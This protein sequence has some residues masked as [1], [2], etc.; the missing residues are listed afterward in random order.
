MA[1]DPAVD[2]P[3]PQRHTRLAD[4]PGQPLPLPAVLQVVAAEAQQLGN[5]VR[6]A[7]APLQPHQAEVDRAASQIH[8]QH[9]APRGQA[10]SDRRSGGLIHQGEFRHLQLAAGLHQP[11]AVTLIGLDRCREHQAFGGHPGRK[12]PPQLLQQQGPGP[13]GAQRQPRACP[14]LPGADPALEVAVQFRSVAVGQTCLQN[15]AAD[16]GTGMVRLRQPQQRGHHRRINEA[17][18]HQ[19]EQPGFLAGGLVRHHGGAAAKVDGH[20]AVAA[21]AGPRPVAL[22][23]AGHRAGTAAPARCGLLGAF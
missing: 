7:L 10:G 14:W 13:L 21:A 2:V 18:G 9:G 22:F 17:V 6:P 8:H 12:R 5:R 19:V 4:H 23:A 20:G 16:Q 3:S 1:G 15:L 11:V